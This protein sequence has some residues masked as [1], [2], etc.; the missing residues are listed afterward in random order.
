M[1]KK[2]TGALVAACLGCIF[3]GAGCAGGDSAW[4]AP[5]AEPD[6][7]IDAPTA[8]GWVSTTHE[9][10]GYAWY[11]REDETVKVVLADTNDENDEWTRGLYFIIDETVHATWLETSYRDVAIWMPP[12]ILTPRSDGT[13]PELG[14][15]DDLVL[16]VE[17]SGENGCDA[18]GYHEVTL[19]I[20]AQRIEV[21]DGSN[22]HRMD[23][24]IGGVFYTL[25][26]STG[27]HEIDGYTLITP[28]GTA[29]E[30]GPHTVLPATIETTGAGELF[31]LVNEA[32][33]RNDGLAYVEMTFASPIGWFQVQASQYGYVEWDI[34]HSCEDTSLVRPQV[35]MTMWLRE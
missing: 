19:T 24:E 29:G 18:L 16:A 31:T 12:L 28:D 14:A 10:G 32:T 13:S 30:A 26:P 3:F 4:D 34:D 21:A 1:I 20:S 15:E 6:S 23:L 9:A 2:A 7:S 33:A 8:R 27:E 5:D 17:G 25:L 35:S 22:L 11:W